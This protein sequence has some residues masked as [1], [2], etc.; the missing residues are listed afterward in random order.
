L[1]HANNVIPVK[2]ETHCDQQMPAF[3]GMTP[4][5]PDRR[6]PHANNV[7]PAKAGTHCDQ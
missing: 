2:A 3:A 5:R 4:G 6:S 7:I 1:P